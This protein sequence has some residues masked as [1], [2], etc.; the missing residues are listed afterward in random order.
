MRFRIDALLGS[1][2]NPHGC[3][4]QLRA[5]IRAASLA[6]PIEQLHLTPEQ[7]QRIRMIFEENKDERQIDQSPRA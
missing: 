2:F 6:D 4:L 3:R 5:G 1:S 7:R